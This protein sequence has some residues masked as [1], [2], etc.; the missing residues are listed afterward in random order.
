MLTTG[1]YVIPRFECN[2]HVKSQFR[3]KNSVLSIEKCPFLVLPRTVKNT[4]CNVRSI[5]CHA[6][7]YGR[8]KKKENI[9]LFALKVVPV[10]YDRWSLTG[11]STES[12]SQSH[13][14]TTRPCFRKVFFCFGGRGMPAA[15]R[16]FSVNA[17]INQFLSFLLIFVH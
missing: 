2:L 13:V 15:Y 5:I 17:H 3:E 4:L 8:F 10:S 6:V 7:V 16:L 1:T 9:K 12:C 11:G 14:I